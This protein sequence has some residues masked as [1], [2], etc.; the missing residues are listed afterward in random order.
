MGIY[1]QSFQKELPSTAGFL[2]LVAL[3]GLLL[4]TLGVDNGGEYS[5]DGHLTGPFFKAVSISIFLASMA[6]FFEV[7][8]DCEIKRKKV[9]LGSLVLVAG[10]FMPFFHLYSG[11][12]I[13]GSEFIFL[14]ADFFV[15]GW[16]SF[17]LWRLKRKKP[18]RSS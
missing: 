9:F 11:N 7:L 13:D 10:Q 5:I 2:R 16:V 18:Y 8:G 12:W 15:L 6:S 1:S 4:M 14:I 17:F 3:A